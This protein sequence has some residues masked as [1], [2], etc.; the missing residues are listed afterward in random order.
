MEKVAVYGSLRPPMYNFVSFNHHYG[1]IEILGE[2]TIQ[3]YDLYSFGSY[4]GAVKGD[5]NLVVTLLE[6]PK[7]CFEDMDCMEYGAGYKREK[8]L[9]N[10][11]EYTM[12]IYPKV[13]GTH[14]PGGDW[15]K[16][17]QNEQMAFSE[18]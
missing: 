7:D 6:V 13:R 16:Y 12:W 10:G 4:P 17:K 8:V 18:V 1:G 11:D 3:G 15:V 5:G 14:V 2:T 9:V